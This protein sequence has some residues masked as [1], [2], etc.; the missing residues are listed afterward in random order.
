ML[1]SPTYAMHARASS[2]L[3]ARMYR[4]QAKPLDSIK[5]T[6]HRRIG[7]GTEV[8]ATRW[9]RTCFDR[10]NIFRDQVL[11]LLSAV[12]LHGPDGGHLVRGLLDSDG[13]CGGGGV[14]ACVCVR[15]CV[16]ACV[17][18]CVCACVRVCFC[19]RPSV[20][21]SIVFRH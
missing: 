18:V 17:R 20:Q 12:H 15:V 1:S 4:L 3:L 5:S 10:A 14:C 21:L 11:E 2:V 19:A 13:V 6:R 7:Y 8:G 9:W 16:C